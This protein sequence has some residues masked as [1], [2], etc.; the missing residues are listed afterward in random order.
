MAEVITETILPG[1]YIEVRAEGLLTVGAIATGNIGVIGTAARGDDQFAN[2]SSYEEGRARFGDVSAWQPGGDNLTMTRTLR[3]LFDNGARTVYARRVTGSGAQAAMLQLGTEAGNGTL[4][5]RARTPGTW[6]NQLE[7][8][9]EPADTEEL[10]SGEVLARANGSFALSASQLPEPATAEASLGSVVVAESGLARKLQIRA[11]AATAQSVHVNPTNRILSFLDAPSPQAEVRA[12]YL[13]PQPALRKVTL[14]HGN[15]R[16]VYIVPSLSY[17]A[18]VLRSEDSPSKL[19]E[20]V[21]VTGDG[22]PR[23]SP[24]FQAFTGGA[25]GDAPQRAQLQ[26]ALDAL[27]EQDVQLVL[28]AGLSF[29]DVGSLLLAH[30]ERA[31]NLGRERIAVVG[32]DSSDQAKV[33]ENANSVADKRVVLVAPG[34]RQADPVTGRPITLPPAYTAAVIV[35]K[36][37]ALPPHISLTNK[38]V[39]G[40]DG[41]TVDY[42]YGELKALVQNRVLALE[43]R[44]GYRVV[45]GITTHD[46]AF[47]QITLRRIVDYVKQGTRQGASQYIGK[48][49]N[50]RV[51]ENLRTT[52][53][54]FLSR[55]V[56][57]E[58]LTG[59]Q[60]R[61]FADRQM[62]IRG[63]VMVEMDLMPTFSI[64]VIRVVM[65]LS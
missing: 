2:L 9:V 48:L 56:G 3:L 19:V 37:A 62:E 41:L 52:L 40:I 24:Q 28:V 38:T 65:N 61:V 16:E 44:R 11:S 36:I 35:G 13:V 58:M 59:Y 50:R 42:N 5:L 4:S 32:A 12:S 23:E 47:Q 14:R 64:D 15:E 29:R 53:D 57:D 21:A 1:T 20:V 45:K 54:A 6:A 39:A 26:A 18:Q 10:V 17:L 55:L 60:L 63:E 31:E 51:R 33:L 25:N 27:L 22:V 34:V 49:N 7:L 8:R 46:E 43:K 30:V